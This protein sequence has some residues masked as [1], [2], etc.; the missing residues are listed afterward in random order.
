MQA[1]HQFN[2]GRYMLQILNLS[3]LVNGLSFQ[4]FCLETGGKD[5]KNYVTFL[6]AARKF[7]IAIPWEFSEISLFS[8]I[9]WELGVFREISLIFHGKVISLPLQFVGALAN[10]GGRYSIYDVRGIAAPSPAIYGVTVRSRW[11]TRIRKW[12]LCFEQ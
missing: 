4:W 11:P 8:K 9:P 6:E 10:F 1:I 2:M 7:A 12:Q 5:M 3:E